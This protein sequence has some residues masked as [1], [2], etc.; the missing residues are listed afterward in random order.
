MWATAY[1][2]DGTPK[3]DAFYAK[4]DPSG[5]R[6]YGTY[7][8]GNAEDYGRSLKLQE[9]G[10]ILIAGYTKSKGLGTNGVFQKT[11]AGRKDAFISKFKPNGMLDWFTYYG[12]PGHDEGQEMD[13]DEGGN[14]YL[15]GDV[16]SKTGIATPGAYKVTLSTDTIGDCMIAKF[17]DRC[18]DRYEPNNT[19]GS[20]TPI[21]VLPNETTIINGEINNAGDIDNFTFTNSQG[22][23]I[24]IQLSD[25]PLNY[26]IYLYAP[27]GQL[28]AQSNKSN[29]Q[30]EEIIFNTSNAGAYTVQVKSESPSAF[31][32]AACYELTISLT[33]CGSLNAYIN[34]SGPLTFCDS[35]S[36]KL[37]V[38]LIDS[39][40]SYQWS[41]NNEIIP[42]ATDSSFTAS[43]AGN[44][45][46]I[47]SDGSCTV[48]SDTILVTEN[49]TPDA[50]IS[51][52][53][54][55]VECNGKK[56]SFTANTGTGYNYQWF[57]NNVPIAD[58]NSPIYVSSKN[59]S[60]YYKV[61]I[62]TDA[63]CSTTSPA[64]QLTRLARPPATI[65]VVGSL[66]ICT[67]G[68]AMLQANTGTNLTYQWSKGSTI[69]TGATEKDYVATTEG[70]YK[71]TVTNSNGCSKTS[72]AVLVTKSCKATITD[73]VSIADALINVYP[74]P[75][76][77]NFFLDIQ[78][79]QPDTE[80]LLKITNIL[81][82][83]VFT[84]KLFFSSN[85]FHENFNLSNACNAGIYFVVVTANG[86]TYS[87]LLTIVK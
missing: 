9:D 51:P 5:N 79:L 56:I 39:G 6:L 69:I 73:E 46:V 59:E 61:T 7:L 12:G 65:S 55:V 2:G 15:T 37:N 4:F 78:S 29:E 87:N 38:S 40:L 60:G 44:Y 62:T 27:D 86:K 81:G 66:D 82:Q 20:A 64:T 68:Q 28:V 19:L 32:D 1:T 70:T 49:P 53:G 10:S 47:V 35:G 25:L 45:A 22:L 14:I 24:N 30:N 23:N 43:A 42:G 52:S 50:T 26:D 18:F 58:N 16:E 75:G 54:N 77:G 3:P 8:G 74:N 85:I 21:V 34:A 31:N 13:V 17:I 48:T 33:S 84:N 36:V 11:Q 76:D 41:I 67:T 71:V 72:S 63:G 83:T 80:G 57:K